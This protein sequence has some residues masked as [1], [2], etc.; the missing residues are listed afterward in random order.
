M[1][2]EFQGPFRDAIAEHIRNLLKNDKKIAKN[3]RDHLSGV[4]IIDSNDIGRN[5]LGKSCADEDA[6]LA[7]KF[8]DNPFGQARQLT[9]MAIVVEKEK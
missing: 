5:I 8:A 6:L 2:Y 7:S 3:L 1:N 4:V 9:P